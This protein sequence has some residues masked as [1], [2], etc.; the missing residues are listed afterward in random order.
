MTIGV[1]EHQAH[2]VRLIDRCYAEAAVVR[3]V[4]GAVRHAL[5]PPAARAERTRP[6]D[7]PAEQQGPASRGSVCCLSS[8][9]LR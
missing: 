2:E 5:E 3:V 7:L 8:V 1:T 4:S 6:Q 9:K